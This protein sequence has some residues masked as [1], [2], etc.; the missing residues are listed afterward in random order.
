[1][2]RRDRITRRRAKG[3]WTGMPRRSR[4]SPR[5]SAGTTR[6]AGP[7]QLAA[8]KSA[9]PMKVAA[10][11]SGLKPYWGKPAVRNF[12]GGGGNEMDGLMAFC[13]ATRKGGNM[14]SY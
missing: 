8:Y 3:L 12:R 14:G 10:D 6:P 1:M 5:H 4:P 9:E 11:E 13:H 2:T 7:V